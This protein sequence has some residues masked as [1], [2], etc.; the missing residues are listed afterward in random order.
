MTY[1]KILHGLSFTKTGLDCA[2]LIEI[3]FCA[4]LIDIVFLVPIVDGLGES[5][6]LRIWFDLD[7]VLRTTTNTRTISDSRSK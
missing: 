1:F 3:V 6:P 4:I 5:R 7:D 2:I